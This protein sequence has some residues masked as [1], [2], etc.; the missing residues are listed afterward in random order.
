MAVSTSV[1]CPLSAVSNLVSCASSPISMVKFAVTL[2]STRRQQ[3]QLILCGSGEEWEKRGRDVEEG[4]CVGG[5]QRAGGVTQ[6]LNVRMPAACCLLV[7]QMEIRKSIYRS[8]ARVE[9]IVV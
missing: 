8:E 3:Q 2:S 6:Q 1:R 4:R 7:V 9:K 5:G